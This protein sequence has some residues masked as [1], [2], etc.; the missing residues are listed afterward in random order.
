MLSNLTS[1]GKEI[2]LKDII[3]QT[4]TVL[5]EG[6]GGLITTLMQYAQLGSCNTDTLWQAFHDLL[7][8]DGSLALKPTLS[9]R[10]WP[11]KYKLKF[12]SFHIAGR[13]RF[14]LWLCK[15]F[16]KV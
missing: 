10:A 15:V 14:G 12:C 13:C 5:L 9:C 8:Q 2:H 6:L 1:G 4:N 16:Y 3:I 11:L 7:V